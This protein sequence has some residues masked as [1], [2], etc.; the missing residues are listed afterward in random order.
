MANAMP[1]FLC[2]NTTGNQNQMNKRL[3]ALVAALDA[4]DRERVRAAR[5]SIQPAAGDID[6]K[7][8]K[9]VDAADAALEPL[10]TRG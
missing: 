10:A 4:G 8:I 6:E 1:A 9:R 3:D 2:S 7:W 5:I